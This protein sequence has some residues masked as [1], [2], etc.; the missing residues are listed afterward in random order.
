MREPHPLNCVLQARDRLDGREYARSTTP[1]I[2]RIP[3]RTPLLSRGTVRTRVS[4]ASSGSAYLL[5]SKSVHEERCHVRDRP[6]AR[7]KQKL[8]EDRP[9]DSCYRQADNHRPNRVQRT[10]AFN[11]LI[12]HERRR[13]IN[14]KR[15][16]Q[17][18]DPVDD[19]GE[20]RSR[21]TRV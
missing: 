14:E 8:R 4:S 9:K 5:P 6:R 20:A 11:R 17:G 21:R 13:R 16:R 1:P 3:T 18:S 15:K 19:T 2:P 7:P 12:D 10:L